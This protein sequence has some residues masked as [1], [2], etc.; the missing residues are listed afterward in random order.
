MIWF[1]IAATV[2]LIAG[3]AVGWDDGGEE[4]LLC[5]LFTAFV[6]GCAAVVV[7]LVFST[8]VDDKTVDGKP[9]SINGPVF[10]TLVDGE[11]GSGL[12]LNLD[13]ENRERY[14]DSLIQAEFRNS[15]DRTF[16]IRDYTVGNKWLSL[17]NWEPDHIIIN[18]P[19][20]ETVELTRK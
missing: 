19:A 12:Q 9:Q 3:I 7:N 2:A 10:I 8:F 13:N 1:I 20:S 14:T 5:F 11:D 16:F 6:L 18:I 4:G 17:F 15:P